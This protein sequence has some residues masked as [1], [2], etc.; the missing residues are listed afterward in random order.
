MKKIASQFLGEKPAF[1]PT[2]LYPLYPKILQGFK[3]LSY[4]LRGGESHENILFP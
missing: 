4:T 2:I 3:S 1:F